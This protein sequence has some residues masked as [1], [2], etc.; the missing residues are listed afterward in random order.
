MKHFFLTCVTMALCAVGSTAWAYKIEVKNAD[1]KSIY[2][3]YINEGKEVEV[4]YGTTKYSGSIDIPEIVQYS[5]RTYGVTSIGSKAFDGCRSL[6]DVTIPNSVTNIGD[7]AFRGCYLLTSVI[8]PNKVTSIGDNAFRACSSLASVSIPSKVTSI[9]DDVFSACLELTAF[10]V[11]DGNPNYDSR[12]NCNAIIETASNTLIAGCMNTVIPNSVTSIGYAAFS[13]CRGLKSVSIPN[14][15]TSIGGNAFFNCD[16]LISAMIPGSVTNIGDGAFSSCSSLTSVTIGSNVTNIGNG[17]FSGCSSL[18]SV[19]IPNSVTSIGEQAF[20][21]CSFLTS[22]MIPRSVMSIENEA[23]SDCIRLTSVT[24]QSNFIASKTYDSSFS[25]K[26]V[27]GRQVGKYI[28][29]EDVTS[30]GASA[31]SGCSGLTSVIIPNSVTSIG[32]DAFKDCN[33]I[34]EVVSFIVEPTSLNQCFSSRTLAIA[35][36]YVPKGTIDKYKATAGWKNFAHIVEGVPDAVE[37]VRE[38]RGLVEVY[39]TDGRKVAKMQRGINIV[40]DEVGVT[41]KILMR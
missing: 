1:G 35:T 12:D 11:E 28:L 29:S 21:G 26:D 36:L 10:S 17:A 33:N 34:E 31:F 38:E 19:I 18:T 13:G 40:H 37:E 4:T 14:G 32:D 15:V 22:V 6:K 23:F 30:I 27:F 39:R 20:F 9:G 8:I 16:R 24:I 25:L 2:Y 5:K 7:D 41:K 3:N